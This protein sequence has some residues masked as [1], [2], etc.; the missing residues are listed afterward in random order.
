MLAIDKILCEQ[1]GGDINEEG[2]PPGFRFHSTDE[3][4]ITFYLVS[5][6]YNCT[7]FGVDIVEVD[8]NKCKPWELPGAGYWKATGNDK[9]VYTSSTVIL[10][11]LQ[12]HF[13]S[14]SIGNTAT[15]ATT[16]LQRQSS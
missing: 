5:K 16:L 11:L 14:S 6:V 3:E 2:M 1:K 7:F 10:P 9:E 8:L 13:Y 15:A 4:F 12:L